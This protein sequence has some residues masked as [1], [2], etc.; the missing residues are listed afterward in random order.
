MAVFDLDTR[1]FN[2]FQKSKL[3][4][5]PPGCCALNKH[6]QITHCRVIYAG[7]IKGLRHLRRILEAIDMIDP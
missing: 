4:L 6:K 3:S 1:E 7:P 2:A 5:V